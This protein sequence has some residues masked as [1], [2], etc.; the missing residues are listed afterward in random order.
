M[1]DQ[2]FQ[3]ALLKSR[4]G[5]MRKPESVFMTTV[6]FMLKM[7]FDVPGYKTAATDGEWLIINTDFYMKLP[8]EQRITLLAHET[9]HVVLQHVNR[10]YKFPD[11]VKFNYAADFVINLMLKEAHFEPI[12]GWLYDKKYEGMTTEEVYN[13]LD[14]DEMKRIGGGAGFDDIR[15]PGTF[16]DKAGDGSGEG[17]TVAE[18]AEKERAITSILAQAAATARQAG[19]PGSVPGEVQVFLDGLLK[20]KLPLSYHLRKFFRAIDKSDYSW[21]KINR[22]FGKKIMLPG[23]HG[24]AMSE[25][26]FAF[27]MSGSVSDRDTLRYVSELHEVLRGLKPSAL[28]LIQFDTHIKSVDRVKSVGDLSRV[29]LVGRGGTCIEPLMQ[30]TAQRKPTALIVF[31]DGE[32]AHPRTNPGVPV[33][34]VV[35]GPSKDSFRCNFGTIIRFNV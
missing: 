12:P 20:P 27:D 26:D 8:A 4:I 22:R 18:L 6:C 3:E 34:W 11:K 28:N 16:A 14:D 1:N 29:K 24:E 21:K 7:Q 33:L 31:T 9:M 15:Q 25:L 2:S 5:F 19:Q 35:H 10:G 30:L 17:I 23:M 13:L 32:Y